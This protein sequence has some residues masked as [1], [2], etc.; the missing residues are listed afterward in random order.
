MDWNELEVDGRVT[1]LRRGLSA[2]VATDGRAFTCD[3][4]GPNPTP[5]AYDGI[6]LD[7]F[8][9]VG[10]SAGAEAWLTG[11]GADGRLTLFGTR[12]ELAGTA[13]ESVAH[14]LDPIGA[15]WAA[16]VLDARAAHVLA[17]DL[18]DG[19]W[20]LRA[21]PVDA[22]GVGGGAAS[23]PRL[24]ARLRARHQPGVLLPRERPARG[25][26]PD[27]GRIR[28]GCL[29]R[30][31]SGRDLARAAGARPRRGGAGCTWRRGRPSSDFR[32]PSGG[33]APGSGSAG[34]VDGRPVAWEV[35]QP[36]LPRPGPLGGGRDAAPR[37]RVRRRWN[38]AVGGPGRAR[39]RRTRRP[40]VVR[41]RDGSGPPAVLARRHRV[42]GPRA[43]R[44][45]LRRR[46]CSAGG[47]VHVCCVGE[48][49]SGRSRTRPD[50]GG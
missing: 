4:H 2:G 19:T 22:A 36:A 34:R 20:R 40:A 30:G 37:P 33:R 42:E 13:D 23:G 6:L 21:Y 7:S 11:R 29:P 27:R 24:R 10:A 44:P 48:R 45:A 49:P 47:A 17:S 38:L 14:P 26:R 43:R 8:G 39:R 12:P 46:A 31:P 35:L 41:R 32:R 18:Q 25:R 28:T 50:L 15:M 3:L 9:V 5:V 16:P 1:A